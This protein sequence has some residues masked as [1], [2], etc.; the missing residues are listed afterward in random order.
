MTAAWTSAADSV[1]G[2]VDF[3]ANGLCGWNG[4]CLADIIRAVP[5]LTEAIGRGVEQGISLCE[6]IL[7]VALIEPRH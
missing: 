2:E 7:P 1:G 4:R 5:R 6:S 3:S